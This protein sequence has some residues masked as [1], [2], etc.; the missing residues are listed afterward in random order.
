M[1]KRTVFACNFDDK[2][3]ALCKDGCSHPWILYVPMAA[4]FRCDRCRTFQRDDLSKSLPVDFHAR[5]SVR[6]DATLTGGQT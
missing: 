4:G 2:P 1:A 5:H 6:C 3:G